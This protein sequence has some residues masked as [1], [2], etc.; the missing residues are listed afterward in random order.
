MVRY[1]S[2]RGNSSGLGFED[3]LLSGLAPDGG[4]YVPESWPELPMESLSGY[5]SDMSYAELALNVIKPFI[6]NDIDPQLLEDILKE[7]YEK[8]FV[9]QDVAPLVSLM[10]NVWVMELFHGPTLA[11]KDFALQV[12]GRLFDHVL[13]RKKQRITIVGATSGDTGSAAI[14]GC[15][16]CKNID[17]FILHPKGRVSDIQRKQMTTIDSKNVYNI[18]VEGTFDDCQNIVKAMF[19]D[20]SFRDSVRLSAINSINWARILSQMVYYV[21]AQ[22]RIGKPVSFSVPTGNFGNIFSAYAAKKM[23][24][25]I[26]SLI[27]GSNRNDIL[28]RFFETGKMKTDTVEPSLSPSMDIQISSNFERYLFDLLGCD[29]ALLTKYMEQFKKTGSFQV[30]PEIY[31]A[32]SKDFLAYR[33]SDQDILSTIKDTHD[34]TGYVLD[35]HTAVGVYAAEQSGFFKEEPIVTLACAHPAKFPEAIKKAIGVTPDLPDRAQHIMRKEEKMQILPNDLKTVQA[36]V[37]DNISS[38]PISA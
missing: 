5:P 6:G 13:E 34:N 38:F 9:H 8:E 14:E 7:T 3:V 23:G 33:C 11:F 37:Q 29:S 30:E 4:L 20:V 16:H 17:L 21:S 26:G 31:K 22:L 18:A 27:I 15:R 10:D 1:H 25:P 19:A 35:P 36:Y 32:L 2:T 24:S 28:T 12:L